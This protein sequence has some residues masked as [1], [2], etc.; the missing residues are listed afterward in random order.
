MKFARLMHVLI[1]EQGVGNI[2]KYR[3]E[4][5]GCL[6]NS[7]E[8]PILQHLGLVA[9]LNAQ[10]SYPPSKRSFRALGKTLCHASKETLVCLPLCVS[11]RTV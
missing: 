8:M 4:V 6:S 9:A 3:A 7:G 10:V 1:Q 2:D 5:K 11:V